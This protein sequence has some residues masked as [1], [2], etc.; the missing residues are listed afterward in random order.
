MSSKKN[1][2]FL[3]SPRLHFSYQPYQLL[4]SAFIHDNSDI[5]NFIMHLGGNLVFMFVFGN[6]VNALLGNILT[7]VIYPLLAIASALVF[8]IFGH[9]QVPLLGASG[10]IFGLAGMYFILFPANR[11]HCAIWLWPRWFGVFSWFTWIKIFTLRG[12]WFLLFYFA[13]NFLMTLLDANENGGGVAYLAH[14]GGFLA[15]AVIALGILASRQINCGGGDILSI[16][17]GKYAWPLIGSPAKRA[18]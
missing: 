17:L 14:V 16:T 10:A 9:S 18:Q 2:V 13:Y 6:R 5:L 4:T 3:D 11:V 12:F 1:G 7:A 15:G 8:Q